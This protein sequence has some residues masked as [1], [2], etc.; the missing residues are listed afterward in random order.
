MSW[1]DAHAIARLPDA[2]LEHEAHAE[3]ASDVLHLRR[4]ALVDERGVARDHEQ[5]GD[6]GEVG[7]QVLG[8]PVG[9][10]FLFGI[11]AHVLKRQDRDRGLLRQRR[12]S[13]RYWR[14]SI[15]AHLISTDRTRNVFELLLPQV[16]A[17]KI[18]SSADLV[19]N[20]A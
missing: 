7:D 2:A 18:D 16:L 19:V 17:V 11:A 20:L 14:S 3:V 5:A 4:P 12:R 13:N 1:A 10:V 9:E 15:Q 6:L 8:D